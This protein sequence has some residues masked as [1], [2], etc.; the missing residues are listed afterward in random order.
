MQFSHSASRGGQRLLCKAQDLPPGRQWNPADSTSRAGTVQD[1][2]KPRV[3]LQ[4]FEATMRDP[5]LPPQENPRTVLKNNPGK[6]RNEQRKLWVEPTCP[7]NKK[8]KNRRK[9]GVQNT[10]HFNHSQA[11]GKQNCIVGPH[12]PAP[13]F[14]CA[15]WDGRKGSSESRYIGVEGAHIP[16]ELWEESAGAHVAKGSLPSKCTHDLLVTCW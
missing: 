1:T 14:H 15:Q 8:S 9:P 16:R 6:M 10:L 7:T 4:V 3:S 11:L 5:P 13:T 2:K 12:F